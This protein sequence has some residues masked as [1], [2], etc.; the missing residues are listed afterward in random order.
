V[1]DLAQSWRVRSELG[2]GSGGVVFEAI[3]PDGRIGALK[4]AH[5]EAGRR[6]DRERRL[7][8]RSLHPAFPALIDAGEAGWFVMELVAGYP[9]PALAPLP[10]GAVAS[11]GAELFSALAAL[12]AAG[13]VH[14]DVA[15]RNVVVQASGRVRLLDL[16]AAT[17]PGA[18]PL[19]LE[20]AVVG[21]SDR[22]RATESGP[23][24]DLFAGGG[25][26]LE[27]LGGADPGPV[28]ALAHALRATDPAA[29]PSAA[30]VARELLGWADAGWAPTGTVAG[31]GGA[32]V[33]DVPLPERLGRYRIDG[34]LG[35][36][37]MGVVYRA[38]DPRLRR[39]VAL[40][41]H[42]TGDARRFE[43]EARAVAA[44]D[45]PAV[46]RILDSGHDGRLAWLALELVEGSTLDTRLARGRVSVESAVRWVA[47][48]AEGLACAHAV[49]LVH[50]DVKPSNVLLDGSDRARLTDFGL[51]RPV[52]VSAAVTRAGMLIGT[53]QYM[54]P[55]QAEG[56]AADAR[57]DV[58]SLGL[59]LF[60]ALAGRPAWVG[61]DTLRLLAAR[62][63]APSPAVPVDVA[64]ELR[65]VVRK[66]IAERPE[67]RY[68]RRR[69]VRAGPAPVGGRRP[70][71]RRG[72]APPS[73]GRLLGGSPPPAARVGRVRC[74]RNPRVGGR[75]RRRDLGRG[76]P[77][78]D[79]EG[80]GSGGRVEPRGGPAGGAR[81][82]RTRRRSGG[83]VRRHGL[84]SP[85]AGHAD[86]VARVAR[87]SR[88][89]RRCLAVR[90]RGLGRRPGLARQPTRGRR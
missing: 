1:V 38:W 57:S 82:D 20:G 85:A 16:G 48:V 46:V 7:L 47:D 62:A 72:R 17:E 42:A 50:R 63:S 45:H 8:A 28:S 76:S 68:P 90:R 34:V 86:V 10:A 60:E 43:R 53:P 35:R 33:P 39:A 51:A 89:S 67:D 55:E 2:S 54:S 59:V 3:A 83:A 30:T 66:A 22:A 49:G 14:R 24:L 64:S 12:H 31:T 70:R 25:V 61:T 65:R 84:G 74:G 73:G 13:V 81:G 56:R 71:P 27:L 69:R 18:A 9:A 78:T 15:L 36:G 6:L 19:T 88:P 52:E 21:T 77:G 11:I 23:G 4:R 44:I 37:G 87:R 29:R 32:V 41:A 26:L 80:G 40:K 58:Y 75:C 79:G 5:P